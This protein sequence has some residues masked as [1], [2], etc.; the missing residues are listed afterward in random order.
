MQDRGIYTE[1][2]QKMNCELALDAANL[3]IYLHGKEQQLIV[4]RLSSISSCK[5][6]NNALQVVYGESGRMAVECEG[7]IARLIYERWLK[8]DAVD[9]EAPGRRYRKTLLVAALGGTVI[10]IVALLYFVLLPWAGEKA[11]ALIPPEIEI[12]LG[13]SISSK[14]SEKNP[15]QWAADSLINVFARKLDLGTAYPLRFHVLQSEEINAFALPG[16]NVFV[17]S[18]IL[19]K[20]HSYE[21]LVALL[22]HEVSHVEHRHSLKSICRSAASGL[23]I[24]AIFGDISGIS[25]G[26]AAQAD[27]FRKLQYSRDLETEA[28]MEA[29]RIMRRNNVNQKGMLDLL[30]LL[31]DEKVKTPRLMK[32]L[33]SHPDT[34]ERISSAAADKIFVTGGADHEELR[35]IFEEL[36]AS[37]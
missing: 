10:L 29:L 35:A 20:M 24:A 37:L 18:G 22:G 17:Y 11:A 15:S 34:D 8:R 21:Q 25:A 6:H 33:S 23:L 2:G 4:W 5:W 3:N 36:V 30:T 27:E 7:A 32:Y 26:I 16:G 28:D 19:C 9:E 13:R 14:L 1:N 31:K 12:E